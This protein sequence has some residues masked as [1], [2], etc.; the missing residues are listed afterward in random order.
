MLGCLAHFIKNAKN[1][2]IIKMGN[3]NPFRGGWLERVLEDWLTE[4]LLFVLLI[5]VK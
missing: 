2:I 1:Y 4:M 3:L 5:E